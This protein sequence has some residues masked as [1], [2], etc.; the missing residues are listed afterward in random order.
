MS[1]VQG[2]AAPVASPAFLSYPAAMLSINNGTISLYVFKEGLLS[3]MGHD[4]RLSVREFRIEADEERVTASFRTDSIRVEGAMRDGRLDD[5]ALSPK[6]KREVLDN[7]ADKVLQSRKFPEIA[8]KGR[9]QGMKVIGDLTMVARTNAVELTVANIGG[10]F[11]W[12]VEIQPLRWG[13]QPYS[14]LFGALKIQDR[15]A[16]EFDIPDA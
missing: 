6:Q 12:R 14:A 15:V 2:F 9:R 4:L 1:A 11:K 7:I 3:A 8:F 10:R 16:V 13:I 5:G